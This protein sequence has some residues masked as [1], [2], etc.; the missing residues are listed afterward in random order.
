MLVFSTRIPTT[1][2][3]HFQADVKND[4][5]VKSDTQLELCLSSLVVSFGTFEQIIRDQK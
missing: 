1:E 5:V 2:G 3:S 4:K